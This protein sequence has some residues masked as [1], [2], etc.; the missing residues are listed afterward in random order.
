MI[1]VAS[2]SVY[3]RASRTCN[4]DC[5]TSLRILCITDFLPRAYIC[6]CSPCVG[7][8]SFASGGG[9]VGVV[10]CLAKRKREGHPPQ[11]RIVCRVYT[12]DNGPRQ[13]HEQEVR[14]DTYDITTG[15]WRMKPCTA[16]VMRG[17]AG[18]YVQR[19]RSYF[20]LAFSPTTFLRYTWRLKCRV[21]PKPSID[22]IGKR[23]QIRWFMWPFSGKYNS[24]IFLYLQHHLHI[25]WLILMIC[26][27][28]ESRDT[29]ILPYIK[30]STFWGFYKKFHM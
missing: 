25:R 23:N 30:K 17:P 21:S 7:R 20:Q 26:E 15:T 13:T 27:L 24:R 8:L 18:S 3:K 28:Q 16:Y 6:T 29:L 1:W 2:I 10:R 5:S 22:D 12:H 11:L 14:R 19:S 9:R 4:V